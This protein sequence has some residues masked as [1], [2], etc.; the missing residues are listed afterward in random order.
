M[1]DAR[2]D[3]FLGEELPE[4]VVEGEL[5][6]EGAVTDATDDA[7]LRLL[8]GA[9]RVVVTLALAVAPLAV[10]V[11]LDDLASNSNSIDI[12]DLSAAV[13]VLAAT[14]VALAAAVFALDDLVTP[15]EALDALAEVVPLEALAATVDTLDDLLATSVAIGTLDA[16]VVLA[17]AVVALAAAVVALAATVVALAAAVVALAATVFALEATVDALNDLIDLAVVVTVAVALLVLAAIAVGALRLSRVVPFM[18][19]QGAANE[20]VE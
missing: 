17:A 19:E 10:G 3:A 2:D 9:N 6:E 13:A 8:A 4:P 7:K 14:V 16:V 5:T 12:G 15:T 18:Q 11:T 1:T 20:E